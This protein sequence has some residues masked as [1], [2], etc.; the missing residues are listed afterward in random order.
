MMLRTKLQHLMRF[1][2]FVSRSGL[3]L[4]RSSEVLKC[5]PAE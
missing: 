3:Q 2:Q 4:I 1:L 5:E